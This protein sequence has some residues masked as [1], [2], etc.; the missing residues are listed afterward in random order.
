MNVGYARVSSKEQELHRQIDILTDAGIDERNIYREKM[1]GTKR[2]RPELNRLI[3]ELKQGDVVI[4]D[5]LTRLSR[6]STDLFYLVEQ[7][8][9]KGANIKSLKESW[10]DTTTPQG[11][12]VFTL[13]AGLSQ[14]ERDLTSERTKEGLQAARARGRFGGRPRK[15]RE[16]EDSIKLLYQGKMKITQIASETGA[17]R[18]TI[19]RVLRGC[20]L[21]GSQVLEA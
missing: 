3:G 14:F 20:G 10:L 5:E 12:L 4:V 1:T 21:L 6:S 15:S 2:E 7:I 9:G 19:Y 17:S 16:K 13:F 18:S 8:Q 11:K